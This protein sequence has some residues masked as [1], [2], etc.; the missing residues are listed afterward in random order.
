[1]NKAGQQPYSLPERIRYL[2]DNPNDYETNKEFLSAFG[3]AFG[4]R[5]VKQVLFGSEPQ[6][7]F[8]EREM[9]EGL[10]K[11]DQSLS[12]ETA[13]NL[14]PLIVRHPIDYGHGLGYHFWRN[15][16]GRYAL[17]HVDGRKES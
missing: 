16:D 13:L 2:L 12:L 7:R 15:P 4:L 11:F 17:R 5:R 14:V 6:W 1:M 9:A 8:S 3:L 10:Q